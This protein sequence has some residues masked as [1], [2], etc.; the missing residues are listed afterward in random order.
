VPI[1]AFLEQYYYG[2]NMTIRYA[3][4]RDILDTVVLSL[5]ESP[6]RTFT[7]VGKNL[8]DVFM[9]QCIV[10]LGCFFSRSKLFS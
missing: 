6:A 9:F 2:Q 7:Y 3:C 4:V 8:P 5:L 1:L 10:F